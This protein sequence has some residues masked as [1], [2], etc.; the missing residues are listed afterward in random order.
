MLR[1]GKAIVSRPY[2]AST[3]ERNEYGSFVPQRE[4][5]FRSSS[6]DVHQVVFRCNGDVQ[7]KDRCVPAEAVTNS[8]GV[9]ELD[10]SQSIDGAGLF[11][12]SRA[13][14]PLQRTVLKCYEVALKASSV[15]DYYMTKY[16]SKAQQVLSAAMGPITDGMRRFE[17][18]AEA[19]MHSSKTPPDETSLASLARAK[20]R[21]MVFSANRSHWFSGCELTIFVLTGGH[22]VQTHRSKEIYLGRAHYMMHE[23]RRLL[24][25]E[26]AETG[27]LRA[28][29]TEVLSV[30]A[31]VPAAPK[32]T[33]STSDARDIDVQVGK[34]VLLDDYVCMAT[35]NSQDCANH[36][37]IDM[38]RKGGEGICD[39][40]ELAA[41]GQ[42]NAE[43]PSRLQTFT[44]TTGLRDDWLH[45][46]FALMDMDLYQYS[47]VIDRMRL[48]QELARRQDPGNVFP[49]DAHYRLATT[50][51]QQIAKWPRTV[52]RL[53]GA[54]CPR[55]D[56]NEGEDY[57]CWMATLFTPVRCPGPGGCADPLQC[58]ATLVRKTPGKPDGDAIQPAVRQ[59]PP[60][61]FAIAWR[62]RRAEIECLA[63]SGHT[64]CNA[65]KRIPVAWDSTLCKRWCPSGVVLA[66]TL[67]QRATVHQAFQQRG[68][69]AVCLERPV[70]LVLQAWGIPSGHHPHQLYLAE[71]CACKSA[72]VIMNINLGVQA[73]NTAKQTAK[74]RS[75]LHLEANDDGGPGE[76]AAVPVV[77]L[78]FEDVGGQDVDEDEPQ[79]ENENDAQQSRMLVMD[80]VH[81]VKWI[82][83][84][85]TREKEMARARQPGRSPDDCKVMQKVGDVYGTVLNELFQPFPV[86][87][88]DCLSFYSFATQAL[89]AQAR[90][91]DLIRRQ[92]DYLGDNAE[93]P[94][95]QKVHAHSAHPSVHVLCIDDVLAGPGQVAHKL[96][97]AGDL[98]QDQ[99]RAVALVAKPMQEA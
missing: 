82:R 70:D 20:L 29:F 36:A 55:I 7:F 85:L 12:G 92:C 51:C 76:P 16:Q 61:S 25:G 96:C 60:Y 24:N 30:V 52:P 4:H 71:F 83:Q 86:Q 88:R 50:Y 63:R 84:L 28:S 69:S 2:I 15:A 6:S 14:F 22:C 33:A 59:E 40:A 42:A 3:N 39:V 11:F 34:E 43:R 80:K 1:R 18:E 37:D 75:A 8:S 19:R 95:V 64:K 5:P 32:T 35:A 54:A 66:H 41:D 67:L 98:P 79:G 49:F 74:K 45:R 48:R 62:Q 87:P 13:L 77:P 72:D 94:E 81:D 91:A 47:I 44:E 68:A 58:C 65:A 90:R 99:M 23:C 78:E 27:P 89:E 73:R 38:E 56:I 10:A 46:G 17:A 31:L 21:R 26:T 97:R 53:V 57:A 9:A 93:Q